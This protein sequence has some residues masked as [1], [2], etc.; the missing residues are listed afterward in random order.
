MVYQLFER[1][2]GVCPQEILTKASATAVRQLQGDDGI[3]EMCPVG[4]AWKAVHLARPD[5]ELHQPDGNHSNVAGAYLT[6]CVFYSVVH[7]SSPEGLPNSVTTS[8]GT[9]L[10]EAEL[11]GFLQRQA[12]TTAENWRKRTHPWFV[13]GKAD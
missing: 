7:R 8:A 1:S 12:W 3:G 11:A 10:I 2:N 6:A 9:V 5:L 13:S 4:E